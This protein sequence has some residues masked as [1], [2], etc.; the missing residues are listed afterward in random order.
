MPADYSFMRR[1]AFD[2]I[3][4]TPDDTLPVEPEAL[5]P[6]DFDSLSLQIAK[7]RMLAML[8]NARLVAPE[9]PEA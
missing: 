8:L 3:R 5:T 4:E 6:D 7:L 9:I 1:P 2:P